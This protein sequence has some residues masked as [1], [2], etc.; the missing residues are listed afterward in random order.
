M[1][2][3]VQKIGQQHLLA[4]EIKAVMYSNIEHLRHLLFVYLRVSLRFTELRGIF[5]EFGPPALFSAMSASRFTFSAGFSALRR[6]ESAAG[7]LLLKSRSV[8]P[9]VG[10]WRPRRAP[11]E[12]S[13]AERLRAAEAAVH[14]GVF[15][16]RRS[17]SG[18]ETNY[19]RF[20]G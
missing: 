8:P 1:Y 18:R 15:T 5:E 2:I 7:S 4:Y 17:R 14:G 6:P 12:R 10:D 3:N 19:V 13:G 9:E 16:W 20:W 11:P